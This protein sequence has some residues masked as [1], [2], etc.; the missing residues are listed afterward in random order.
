[1]DEP[2][3]DEVRGVLDGH[4]VLERRVAARGQYPAVDLPASL[5]R[6]MDAVV[7]SEHALAARKLRSLIAAYEDKR[8]L[9]T[10]GAYAKGSDE[11]ERFLKQPP[12][13]LES[14]ERTVA[15]LRTLAGSR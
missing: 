10:L 7:T 2:I 6:V 4:I 3:A 9:I 15:A 5:S 8:D 11:I 12:D 1:M 13:E 14:F